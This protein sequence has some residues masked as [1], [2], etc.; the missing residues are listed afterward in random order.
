[1]KKFFS[2]LCLGCAGLGLAAPAAAAPKKCEFLYKFYKDYSDTAEI[3]KCGDFCVYRSKYGAND[4]VLD[5]ALVV[6]QNL[7][8]EEFD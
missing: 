1:M 3:I 4:I 6:E 2:V 5:C 8:H 7:T